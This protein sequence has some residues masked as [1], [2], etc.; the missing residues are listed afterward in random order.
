[1]RL[2]GATSADLDFLYNLRNHESVR[3]HCF[4]SDPITWAE[5]VSWWARRDE[6]VYVGER[7]GVQVGYLRLK[8]LMDV[9]YAVEPFWRGH[10]FATEMLRQVDAGRK[11][12]ALIKSGNHASMRAAEHAGFRK[13]EALVYA[14]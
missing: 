12:V 11:A 13:V 2:R 5:H 4:N 8:P 3:P 14:R 1:M 10:G 7:D 9:T 6:T